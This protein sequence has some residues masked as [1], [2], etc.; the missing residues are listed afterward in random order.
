M[1]YSMLL[2]LAI[3]GI[4]C[5]SGNHSGAV[6]PVAAAAVDDLQTQSPTTT[7]Q[8]FTPV[9]GADLMARLDAAQTRARSRQTPYWS[10]YTFDVRS[11]GAV[12]AAVREFIGNMNP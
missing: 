11:G 10:A 5:A 4:A 8:S 1:R 7:I 12:D 2:F 9:E 6:T 3:I